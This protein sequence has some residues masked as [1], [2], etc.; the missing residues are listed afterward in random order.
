MNKATVQPA[1]R[2]EISRLRRLPLTVPLLDLRPPLLAALPD[3]APSPG[4]VSPAPA[5]IT[6]I[7]A[8]PLAAPPAMVVVATIVATAQATS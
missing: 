4:P 2:P 8:V 3:G 7:V 6:V 5:P 1:V